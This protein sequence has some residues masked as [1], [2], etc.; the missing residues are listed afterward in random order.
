METIWT[1][2]LASGSLAGSHRRPQTP[3]TTAQGLG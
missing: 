1:A 2:L 3:D